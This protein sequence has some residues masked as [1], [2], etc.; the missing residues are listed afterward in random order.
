MF[1]KKRHVRIDWECSIED[2]TD[3]SVCVYVTFPDYSR[4]VANFYTIKCIES[5]RNDRLSRGE[6]TFVWSEE[7]LIIVDQVSRAHIEKIIDESMEQ[8]TFEYLF[9]Y[10]GSVQAPNVRQYPDGF[11]ENEPMI[12]SDIVMRQAGRL[13]EMLE[14]A[15]DELKDNIKRFLFDDRKVRIEHLELIPKLEV[16]SM[17]V[18][19][20][21]HEGRDMKREWEDVFA[22]GLDAEEKTNIYMEQYLWHVFSY[23]KK[24]CLSDEQAVEAFRNEPKKA[25]YVFYQQ[26]DLVLFL[27]DAARL[28]PEDVEGEQ[29]IYIVDEHFK[30][31]YVVTHESE[32]GPYF[33]K[34]QHTR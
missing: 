4:W 16:K 1:S 31:T 21:E 22:E 13:Y 7:N 5:I 10:F 27:E 8:N 3:A 20:A 34:A 26:H 17:I 14:H 29:D 25:C 33:V 24:P 12:N 15:S 11:F 9:K 28:M 2:E 6:N 32:L 23:T 18:A 30:W 19:E